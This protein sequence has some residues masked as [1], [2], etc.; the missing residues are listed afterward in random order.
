MGCGRSKG[1]IAKVKALKDS[2][3]Q[4]VLHT[5]HT[6]PICEITAY[7][8]ERAGD[9]LQRLARSTLGLQL[10]LEFSD[11]VV[12]HECVLHDAGIREVSLVLSMV[13]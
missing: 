3:I 4:L 12:P 8:L 9:L 2:E 1:D 13:W 5:D 7:G 11:F 6:D 10:E